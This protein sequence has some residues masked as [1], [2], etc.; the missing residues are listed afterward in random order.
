[1]PL[2]TVMGVAKTIAMFVA[3]SE[4]GKS[5]RRRLVFCDCPVIIGCTPGVVH[6]AQIV[7]MTT[8]GTGG[9]SRVAA[10]KPSPS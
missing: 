1:M 5:P 3:T 7:I 9:D 4:N 6:L 2:A 8:T 10:M